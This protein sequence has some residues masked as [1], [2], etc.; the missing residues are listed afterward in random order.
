MKHPT[1]SP[2]SSNPAASAPDEGEARKRFPRDQVT[3]SLTEDELGNVPMPPEIVR[4]ELAD[5]TSWDEAADD[6]GHRVEPI[7][8]E[9]ETPVAELLVS[10]GLDEAEEELRSLDEEQEQEEESEDEPRPR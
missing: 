4:P 2:P 9:D 8:S 5:L 7:I 10:E 6:T 1:T 3:G